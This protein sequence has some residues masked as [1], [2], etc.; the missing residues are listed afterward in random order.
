[1]T[2]YIL[3]AA[4]FV[5][6]GLING[7]TGFGSMLF[8][9]PLMSLY[10]AP[11]TSV[12]LAMICE[13]LIVSIMGFSLWRYLEWPKLLPLLL[14]SLPGVAVGVVL[15]KHVDAEVF[16]LLL[17]LMIVGYVSFT[18]LARPRPRK[19]HWGVG[20]ACASLGGAIATA[21]SAGGPPVIIYTA[22]QDWTPDQKRTTLNGF[23]WASSICIVAT[24][25]AAGL[26][27]GHVLSLGLAAAPSIF[28]GVFAGLYAARRI[29]PAAYMRVVQFML[30]G[31]GLMLLFG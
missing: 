20:A 4:I 13:V 6:A 24:H 8:A 14:G 29:N 31:M 9:V 2:E 1:L 30:L 18:L 5:V 11:Q 16:R 7:L 28:I 25:A 23:F 22:M 10:L 21:F 17:G 15:L 12:P 27:D 26:T 19:I 3:T